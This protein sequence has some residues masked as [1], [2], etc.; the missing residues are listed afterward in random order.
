MIFYYIFSNLFFD[1]MVIYMYY[2]RDIKYNNVGIVD[3]SDGTIEY[4]PLSDYKKA[5]QKGMKV[6]ENIVLSSAMPEDEYFK[7]INKVRRKLLTMSKKGEGK[8]FFV[9]FSL[10]DLDEYLK[11]KGFKIRRALDVCD[12]S[13]TREQFVYLL[14]L[15]TEQFKRGLCILTIDFNCQVYYTIVPNSPNNVCDWNK[16]Q[17]P[18]AGG[19]AHNNFFKVKFKKKLTLPE[20]DLFYALYY[21][22][23]T[24]VCFISIDDLSK[25]Y[26]VANISQLADL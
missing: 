25:K 9:T 6:E 7:Y 5:L 24:G 12:Y 26:L 2:I 10:N 22:S 3:T 19:V 18:C 23:N 16:W 4:V 1:W 14:E 21:N 11:S 13:I 17:Y 20:N 8:E 15:E